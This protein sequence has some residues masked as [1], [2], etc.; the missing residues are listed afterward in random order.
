MIQNRVATQ[1]SVTQKRRQMWIQSRDW[2]F[3]V[4]ASE[5]IEARVMD[6]RGMELSE[7]DTWMGKR[8]GKVVTVWSRENQTV[9]G[10]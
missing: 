10:A 6:F 1:E 2:P 3:T 5:D 9:G 4:P 8:M 7:K